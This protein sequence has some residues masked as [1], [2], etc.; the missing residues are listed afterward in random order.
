ML[1]RVSNRYFTAAAA[2]VFMAAACSC[3]RPGN[4][5]VGSEYAELPNPWMPDGIVEFFP[6][7]Y[8]TLTPPGR[9]YSLVLSLRYYRTITTSEVRLVCAEM[10]I[11]SGESEPD[12]ITVKLQSPG[13]LPRGKG[14]YNVYEIS[15]TLRRRMT[16]PE[17]YSLSVW[18][19][20]PV[21]GLISVGYHLVP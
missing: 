3:I 8:D 4:R 13:G 15:D 12:T 6:Q 7:P 9:Q 5:M 16:I 19:V 2:A 1:R 10:S 20:A 18:P 17:G 14:S 21:E 11:E